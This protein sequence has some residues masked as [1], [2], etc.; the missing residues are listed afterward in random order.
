MKN[1]NILKG[2]IVLFI[3]AAMVFSSVAIAN[4]QEKETHLTLNTTSEGAGQSARG[5]IVWDNGMDYIGL[6]AA[7][8]DTSIPF[9]CFV[10][11][12]FIFE[13][14]TEVCDVH[15]I[16]GY[17]NPDPYAEFDWCISFYLD[18]GSGAFPI[19][20][21]YNPSFAGPF[22]YSWGDITWEELEPGYYLMSV[23]LPDNIPFPAG[24]YWISIWGAGDYP[25]QCGWGYHDTYILTPA[26]WGSVYFGFPFWTPGYDVQGFDHDT[27]FQLTTKDEA[28]PA[29]C[30][31]PGIMTWTDVVPGSTVTGTFYVWNCG[32]DNSTLKWKVDTWPAWMGSPVFTPNSGTIVAPG[33][34]T[35]VTFTFTAP[36]QQNQNFAGTI[37]VVNEDDTSDYCEMQ[38]TLATPR[39]KQ[40]QNTFF[41]RLL[42]Q[43]PNAFPLLRYIMGI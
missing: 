34:G 28:I 14:P 26:V 42:Q 20:M 8:D 21:P 16:G 24:H 33:A 40:I 5:T 3:V 11:D 4:T 18:D 12:D 2:A 41:L 7:Q 13:E 6:A 23:D 38:T 35:D 15:W 19:G 43:F 1:R 9:D 32:D 17:W 36:N 10:A 31:D 39:M 29:V 25:P 22:C 27:C 37:K 30:C